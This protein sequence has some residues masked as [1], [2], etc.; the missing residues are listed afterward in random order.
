M[1][2][3]EIGFSTTNAVFSWGS[4]TLNCRL[5][6]ERYPD[7]NAVIP[8]QNPNVMSIERLDL[9]NALKRIVIFTNRATNQVRWKLSAAELQLTGEDTDYSNEGVE[10]LSCD[11]EGDPMEIGFNAKMMVDILS[12]IDSNLVS[13]EMSSPNRPG[14]VMPKHKD[15]AEDVLMLAMPIMLTS[16][17]SV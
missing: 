17:V 8:L 10:R 9:L 4:I 7:Y 16:M 13:I 5:I 15:D 3:V 2:T 11:Y 1:S 14:L 12:N 6:D